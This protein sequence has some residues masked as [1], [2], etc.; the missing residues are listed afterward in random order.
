MLAVEVDDRIA[1]DAVELEPA[2][3]EAAADAGR[4]KCLR[5]QPLLYGRKPPATCRREARSCPRRRN[6]ARRSSDTT[7]GA[8]STSRATS[9]ARA[10][11]T[12]SAAAAAAAMRL[13][14]IQP[15]RDARLQE[16]VVGLGGGARRRRVAA[17]FGCGTPPARTPRT[18]RRCRAL[19]L[20]PHVSPAHH[21]P[22]P[23]PPSPPS[24]RPNW[25]AD[26][27]G[28]R[29]RN[30][31]AE[32]KFPVGARKTASAGSAARRRSRRAG[33]GDII[34]VPRHRSARLGRGQRRK[35]PAPPPSQPPPAAAPPQKQQRP[36]AKSAARATH[37]RRRRRR[38]RLQHHA[39]GAPTASP[40][41]AMAERAPPHARS[42]RPVRGSSSTYNSHCAASK[43]KT[44]NANEG[45]SCNRGAVRWRPSSSA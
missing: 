22:P 27:R 34:A 40:S 45:K 5:Y 23:P 21:R 1:L 36:A 33:D 15:G 16:A 29:G 8:S 25:N 24:P 10:S 31:G 44:G 32:R 7:E 35:A 11:R 38:P 13:A 17:V 42:A 2:S 28:A 20:R 30:R 19:R 9:S 4:S 43:C 39:A 18:P 6:R 37:H 14:K 12:R 41:A 3:A 26:S